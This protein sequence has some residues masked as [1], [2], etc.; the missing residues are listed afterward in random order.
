MIVFIL[1]D[2]FY[3]LSG[4]RYPIPVDDEHIIDVSDWAATKIGGN[5]TK[6]IHADKEVHIYII[7]KEIDYKE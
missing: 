1:S 6:I 7:C 4:V 5:L 2:V 3:A